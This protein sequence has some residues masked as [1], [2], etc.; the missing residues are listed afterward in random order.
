ML[1]KVSK[2][3][4]ILEIITFLKAILLKIKDNYN[5]KTKNNF[6]KLPNRKIENYCTQ[7]KN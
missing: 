4:K 6:Q 1:E 7:Y 5:Y 3:Q 2:I